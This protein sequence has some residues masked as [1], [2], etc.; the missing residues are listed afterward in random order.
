MTL[1]DDQQQAPEAVLTPATVDAGYCGPGILPAIQP[2]LFGITGAG[3]STLVVS[4]DAACAHRHREPVTQASLLYR[5]E[6]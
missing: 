5:H 3:K 1:G 6:T 4:S 2:G